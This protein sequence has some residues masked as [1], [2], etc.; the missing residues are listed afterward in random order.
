[1]ETTV[2]Y[3]Q[4]LDTVN[5]YYDEYTESSNEWQKCRYT[6][7][8]SELLYFDNGRECMFFADNQL[9]WEGV[10]E[11]VKDHVFISNVR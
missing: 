8:E 5:E 2:D 10:S 1:M 3:N 9:C 11:F 4:M 7:T 6:V